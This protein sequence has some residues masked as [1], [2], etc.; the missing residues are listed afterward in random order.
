MPGTGNNHGR[1]LNG[2]EEAPPASLAIDPEYLDYLLIVLRN[3][4]R[5]IHYWLVQGNV[6]G[7]MGATK[8]MES[9]LDQAG[10]RLRSSGLR[11]TTPGPPA[12]AVPLLRLQQLPPD[13]AR[14][15]EFQPGQ[16]WCKADGSPDFTVRTVNGSSVEID[17][18]LDG[19]APQRHRFEKLDLLKYVINQAVHPAPEPY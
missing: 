17:W 16:V 18:H 14:R 8:G 11:P 7:A 10:V 19:T 4:T 3:A 1:D 12:Q 15:N 6:P 5:E 13:R 9:A 2:G